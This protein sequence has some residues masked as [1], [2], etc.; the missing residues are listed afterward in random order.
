MR[1]TRHVTAYK[2]ARPD[3]WDFHTGNT[4]QYRSD[5]YP[6][7]V[8]VPNGDA[9]KGICSD[10]VGHASKN[11]NDCFVGAAIPCSAF[12][13]RFV[14]V[15][16]NPP[17]WGWLEAEVLEEIIPPLDD[18]FGWKY[19]EMCHPLNPLGLPLCHPTPEDMELLK[20]WHSVRTSVRT[21]VWTSVRISMGASVWDTVE[22]SMRDSVRISMGDSV[23]ISMGASVW[24]TVEASV[25]ISMRD[26]MWDSIGVCAWAYIGS[27]FPGISKWRHV[28]HQQGMYPFQ[29]V[30]DLWK[31]GLVPSYD[32]SIW[33]LHSGPNAQIVAEWRPNAKP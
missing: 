10:G 3:G 24:D 19:E 29:S 27:L 33:R 7:T 5:S 6:Y 26:S 16:G 13:L 30:V 14:P 20:V 28:R 21:S 2:L 17:K 18:L 12:R 8:R 11:P 1:N 31:R 32:G 15:C 22:A 25:R 9:S 23:R 4:I